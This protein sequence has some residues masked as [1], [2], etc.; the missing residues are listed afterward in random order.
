MWVYLNWALGVTSLGCEVKWLEE[1][2]P[3]VPTDAL[4]DKIARLR[5]RLAPYGLGDSLAVCSLGGGSLP[6]AAG[7]GCLDLEAAAEAD[8]LLDLSYGVSGDVVGRFPRSALIDIDPGLTQI[9]I[10]SGS[11][12]LAEHDAYFTTGEMVGKPS[13]RFP[14]AGIEWVHAAPCVS[15]EWWPPCPEVG[16]GAFTTVAHWYDG[17]EEFEGEP[18]LNGKRSGFL[19][20]FDLPQWTD[21]PLELALD[22]DEED[23]D[24]AMLLERGWRLR[25][26]ADVSA[27]PWDFQRYVQASRG[28]FSCAK[29]AYVRLETGWISDR[30]VCYLASGKPVVV[31]YTGPSHRLEDGAGA[32]R[33]RDL[34]EAA[35]FLEQAS[36]D[37][38]EQSRLAR[39]LAEEHFDASKVA[40]GVLERTLA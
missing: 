8:M 37:Y 29:P 2:P 36:N 33:F 21:Q 16:E 39:A 9:W 6:L 5:D 34:D 22:L 25:E 27:T 17:W 13:A 38:D 19:P 31:Q 10:D 35:R 40:R 24:R 3:N 30:S 12:P 20:F 28:E 32:F 23:E 7:E 1:V 4:P 26:A 15:L 14:S 18:F 11:L